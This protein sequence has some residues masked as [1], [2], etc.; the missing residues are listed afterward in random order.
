MRVFLF[1]VLFVLASCAANL[2]EP[3]LEA[4]LSSWVGSSVHDL[5][6]VL[7]EPTAKAEDSWEWRFTGPGMPEAASTSSIRLPI[8]DQE[9]NVSTSRPSSPGMGRKSWTESVDSAIARKECVYRASVDG[10]TVVSIETI[11]VSGRCQFG[12][13]SLQQDG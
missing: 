4:R 7:G 3:D 9:V 10:A 13:I 12:E 6:R 1:A 11:A 8:E 5:E 2:K